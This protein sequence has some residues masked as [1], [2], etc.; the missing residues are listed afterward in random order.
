VNTAVFRYQALAY[1]YSSSSPFTVVTMG[2]QKRPKALRLPKVAQRKPVPT[3]TQEQPIPTLPL[4][5]QVVLTF[6][7]DPL[8]VFSTLLNIILLLEKIFA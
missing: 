1:G 6:K 3:A 5:Q 2:R 8:A 4:G 7:K